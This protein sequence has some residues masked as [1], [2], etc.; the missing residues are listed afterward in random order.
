GH[1]ATFHAA[2]LWVG[3]WNWSEE[4]ALPF[5]QEWNSHCEPPWEE[6]DLV[7]K[8]N[9]ANKHCTG[10]RGRLRDQLHEHNGW[11]HHNGT[12]T[13]TGPAP[14]GCPAA[15]FMPWENGAADDDSS[16]RAAAMPRRYGGDW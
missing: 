6:R 16:C 4:D 1:D 11:H 10:P 9:E 12:N 7:R 5:M 13:Q 2:C 15:E 14:N 8:L 3:D